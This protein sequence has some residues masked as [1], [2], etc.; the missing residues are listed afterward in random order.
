M[1]IWNFII[2]KLQDGQRIALLVVIDSDGSSPGQP[3]FKMAVASDGTIK[4][5]VGG[6]NTEYSIVEKARKAIRGHH[7]VPYLTHHV[8]RDDAPDN[9]SGLICSGEHWV[10]CYLLTKDELTTAIEIREALMKGKKGLITF[11]EKGIVFESGASA[12]HKHKAP[13]SSMDEWELTEETGMQ[14]EVYIFGAGHV[15]LALSQVMRLLGFVVHIFDDREDISTMREN[16]AAHF[17]KVISYS[18]AGEQLPD[19]DN[20]YAVIMTFGHKSDEKVLRQLLGRPIKYLGMMG[21][22]RKVKK[23]FENLRS[24]GIE[25]ELLK[26]VDAPIGMDIGSQTPPEIAISVAAKI[27]QVKNG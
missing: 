13:V 9:R 15:G 18:E 22:S 4:G 6:G 14:L 1:E 21:S 26:L 11:S 24:E 2:D 27:I 10:A 19:G 23:I 12:H 16:Q 5:S 8:H 7:L 25:E 17:S 3:G 20:I